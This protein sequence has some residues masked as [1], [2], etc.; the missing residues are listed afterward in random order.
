MSPT[1]LPVDHDAWTDDIANWTTTSGSGLH[2]LPEVYNGVA[3]HIGTWCIIHY[4]EA[5]LSQEHEWINAL[6]SLTTPVRIK[7]TATLDF[8]WRIADA[9]AHTPT[10]ASVALYTPTSGNKYH[11]EFDGVAGGKFPFPNSAGFTHYTITLGPGNENVAGVNQFV[12][13][14]TGNWFDIEAIAI[15]ITFDNDEDAAVSSMI[16]AMYFSNLRW[17][18]YDNDLA[19]SGAAYGQRDLVVVDDRLHSTADAQNM[20]AMLL[21][22]H[23]DPFLQLDITTPMDTNI[24]IGDRI[25]I[26][27]ANE[28]LT[29]Q[30]FDVI[31]V[32]HTMDQNGF[33]TK[34]TMISQ[35]RV[36]SPSKV[37][38]P[39]VI[40]RGLKEQLASGTNS[41]WATWR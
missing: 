41:Q 35:A 31:R 28:G 18:D 16:D 26:T 9:S 14:G 12:E 24:L 6:Y 40:M 30:D 19:G 15:K 39:E 3:P 13:V 10:A 11:F 38:N 4:V 1:D 34:S 5:L 2:H 25:P 17:Q 21:A 27:I 33:L 22:K 20:A 7:D 36:R 8:V 23:K 29:A 32:E 37:T